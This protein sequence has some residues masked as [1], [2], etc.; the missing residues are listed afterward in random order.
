MRGNIVELHHLDCNKTSDGKSRWE[1]HK[2]ARCSFKQFIEE[3]L[4]EISGVGQLPRITQI[5]Y[6]IIYDTYACKPRAISRVA[7]F[8]FCDVAGV[9]RKMLKSQAGLTKSIDQGTCDTTW[10]DLQVLCFAQIWKLAC[11]TGANPI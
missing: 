8:P 10:M 6:K 7:V 5:K 4:D 9:W 1:L 3:G 11:D 2:Y